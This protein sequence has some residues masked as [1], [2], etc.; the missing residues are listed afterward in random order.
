MSLSCV[1][2]IY[3]EER[4]DED[5]QRAAVSRMRGYRVRVGKREAVQA[6]ECKQTE[7][8]AVREKE[9]SQSY[10]HQERKQRIRRTYAMAQSH[11]N[12][13]TLQSYRLN[14]T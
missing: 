13:S 14:L 10:W 3:L 9:K 6:T 1:L 8:T 12:Y 5:E 4:S 7:S 11:S 2:D